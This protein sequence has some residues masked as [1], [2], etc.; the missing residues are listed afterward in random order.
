MDEKN[1][2]KSPKIIT[3]IHG[4][5][6]DEMYQ[7]MLTENEKFKKIWTLINLEFLFDLLIY[8]INND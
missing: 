3:D 1:E 4:I 6:K 7:Q 5:S 8:N 2:R